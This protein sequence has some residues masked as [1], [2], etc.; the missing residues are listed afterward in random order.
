M[1]TKQKEKNLNLCTQY[2]Y[3]MYD[4]KFDYVSEKNIC[5]LKCNY[6]SKY[7]SVD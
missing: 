6:A 3:K 1:N 5:T 4:T 2:Y 7:K